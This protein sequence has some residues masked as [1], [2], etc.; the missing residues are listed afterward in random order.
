[1]NVCTQTVIQVTSPATGGARRQVT[2]AYCGKKL[3]ASV[4]QLTEIPAGYLESQTS[5][6]SKQCYLHTLIIMSHVSD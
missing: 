1:L 2:I 5:R 3:V 6:M 4:E